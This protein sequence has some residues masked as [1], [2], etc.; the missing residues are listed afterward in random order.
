MAKPPKDAKDTGAASA[1]QRRNRVQPVGALLPDAGGQ[2]FRRFGFLQGALL[3]RWRE[4][5]GPVYAR[6]SLPES[7][8]FPRGSRVGGTLVVRVQG[9]FVVQLQHVAPQLVDR[10]NR[11]LGAGVVARLKLVQGD[12][13][14][15]EPAP[16]AR[17]TNPPAEPV[18]E[19]NLA[20]IG[21]DKLRAALGELAAAL[22]RSS[23]PP[24]ID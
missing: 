19:A 14:A 7:I 5:V 12:V 9:P 1:G 2:A 10:A 16:D 3:A 15:P 11:I 4:V 23:G 24:R 8:R 20:G 6:W 17:T 13:P 18:I 22:Q 21:D